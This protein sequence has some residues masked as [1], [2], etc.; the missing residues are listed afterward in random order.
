M[1]SEF[2]A[3]LC[4]PRGTK[5]FLKSL[6]I[7]RENNWGKTDHEPVNQAGLDP[8]VPHHE[9]VLDSAVAYYS[10]RITLWI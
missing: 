9:G 4:I 3:K 2:A 1:F 10:V 5:D 6:L 7:I 8:E